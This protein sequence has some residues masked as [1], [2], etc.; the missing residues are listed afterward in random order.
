M[1]GTGGCCHRC[2]FVLAL[3]L[4]APAADGTLPPPLLLLLLLP[5]CSGRKGRVLPRRYP[6]Y[7][8]VILTAYS[9]ETYSP[10]S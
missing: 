5:V 10:V 1:V 7:L 2:W 3:V 9:V 4:T 6:G 8:A